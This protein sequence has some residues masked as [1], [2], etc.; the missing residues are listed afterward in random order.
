MAL[1][2]GVRRIQRDRDVDN[3]ALTLINRAA[4]NATEILQ[5][6]MLHKAVAV[7]LIVLMGRVSGADAI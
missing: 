7:A 3:A 1:C 5:F 4:Q 2:E 6:V